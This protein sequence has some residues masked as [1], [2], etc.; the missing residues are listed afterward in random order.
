MEYNSQRNELV[1]REYG[2]I[3]QKMVR[4]VVDVE[5]K[6]KRNAMA[7]SIIELM[8]QASPQFKNIEE[9]R[10]KLWDHLI[11]I[12]DFKLKIDSP[13]PFPERENVVVSGTKPLPYPKAKI[14]MRHY[15]K[16]LEKL[17]AKTPT[18][19]EEKRKGMAAVVA[20]YM[21][22][23]YNN[24]SKENVSDESIRQDLDHM[25]KGLLELDKDYT[26][27]QTVIVNRPQEFRQGGKNFRRK[28]GHKKSR[29]F[30]GGGG[31][32]G[33]GGNFKRRRER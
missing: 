20:N 2:R 32:G 21:K 16:N 9:Y 4:V 31:S 6:E 33:G 25:S 27:D 1:I 8:S 10:H 24:W 19:D 28:G 18:I 13:Y 26:F 5:D 22:L 23:C 29:N 7:K 30:K 14:R 12:S 15:G 17:V 11:I 3:I